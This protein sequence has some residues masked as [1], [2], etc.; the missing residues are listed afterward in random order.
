VI[1]LK[2]FVFN[3]FQE[4][5]YILSDESK[6][7]VLIDA[8]FGTA[9]E[10]E[11]LTQY[12][13]KQQ[14]KI[15]RLINTHGHVDHVLGVSKAAS[16]FGL[17]P[18]FYKDEIELLGYVE[19]QGAMFGM[20]VNK[21]PEIQKFLEENNP[22]NFGNSSLHVLHVPGHSKGSVTFYSKPDK[23]LITGDVLFKGSIGRTDLPGGDYDVLMK[24]IEKIT[25]LGDDVMIFPG[26]GPASTIGMELKTN[27]FLNAF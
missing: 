14:L 18:E 9:K 26:H 27:P 5:T 1:T 25:A 6:E 17:L 8:G 24:S 19:Q 2:T 20:N 21:L 22:V 3:P 15:V 23:L 4:N 7:A 16:Y 13:E 10:F 11:Q 12:I